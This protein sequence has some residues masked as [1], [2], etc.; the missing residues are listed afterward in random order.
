[1]L[2]SGPIA[3]AQRPATKT[4]SRGANDGVQALWEACFTVRNLTGGPWI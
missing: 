3:G 4:I 2:Y 1:M